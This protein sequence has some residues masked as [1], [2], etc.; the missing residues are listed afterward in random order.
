MLLV[1]IG[2]LSKD[3]LRLEMLDVTLQRD[4]INPSVQISFLIVSRVSNSYSSK[5]GKLWTNALGIVVARCHNS[6]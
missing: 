1:G 3:M 2:T 5:V 6:V 4:G